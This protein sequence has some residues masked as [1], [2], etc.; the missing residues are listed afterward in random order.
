MKTE[1]C[2]DVIKLYSR[3]EPRLFSPI[4]VYQYSNEDFNE[5]MLKKEDWIFMKDLLYKSFEWTTDQLKCEKAIDSSYSYS[6]ENFI[7]DVSALEK[8]ACAK[9]EFICFFNVLGILYLT[10]LKEC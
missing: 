5:P 7:P 10:L 8:P 2:T 6:Y 4:T 9:F 3:N 1:K